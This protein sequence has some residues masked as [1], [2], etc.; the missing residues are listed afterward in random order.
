M[1]LST[2]VNLL[3]GVCDRATLVRLRPAAEVDA[4]LRD[5]ILERDARGRYAL[6]TTRPALR[7]ANR[8]AGIVVAKLGTAVATYE[9]V[10]SR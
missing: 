3:G 2:Q 6:A 7:T 1:N 8:A 5:G 9:E 4:A 10:F